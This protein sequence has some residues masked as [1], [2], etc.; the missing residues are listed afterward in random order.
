MHDMLCSM[1]P[2]QSMFRDECRANDLLFE[3]YM[4]TFDAGT[5]VQFEQSNQRLMGL[6]LAFPDEG[7]E[8]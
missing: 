5:Y 2:W 8:R 3:T 1:S 7:G 6:L 4:Q